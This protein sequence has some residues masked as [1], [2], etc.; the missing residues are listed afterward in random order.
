MLKLM[1]NEEIKKIKLVLRLLIISMVTVMVGLAILALPRS[2]KNATVSQINTSSV[3]INN[4]KIDVEI[5]K[6]S[7]K[8]KLGLCCRDSLAEDKGMLFV[9]DNSAVRK[10]WMKDTRIPLDM[11]W[12]DEQNKII[13]I[14]HSVQPESYP[15]SFGS[16]L[17][18]RYVL[19]TNAGYAKT[20]GIQVGQTV[21]LNL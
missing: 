1:Q 5:A 17:P 10:F 8:Q 7:Q 3:E 19:E 6:T 11:Y 21:E 18:S 9:Y 16:D 20:H 14:E 4:R 13:Y 2:N 12:L 15:K